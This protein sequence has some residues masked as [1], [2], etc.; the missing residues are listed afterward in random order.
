MHE[1][2]AS[3]VKKLSDIP[4]ILTTSRRRVL[5]VYLPA[6]YIALR[7]ILFLHSYEIFP[8]Q[9]KEKIPFPY[10]SKHSLYLVSQHG[11]FPVRADRNSRGTATRHRIRPVRVALPRRSPARRHVD[12]LILKC[13]PRR[14]RQSVR[15]QVVGARVLRGGERGSRR[16]VPVPERGDGPHHLDGLPRGRLDDLVEGDRDAVG[17]RAARA[18]RGR[19]GGGGAGARRGRGRAAAAPAVADRYV[20]AGQV[21]LAGLE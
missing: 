4:D 13:L 20:G 5:P 11:L 8:N 15:P 14:Q 7:N 18:G 6:I 21:D 10:D 2:V 19:R 17:G 12:K 9:Q 16:D 3:S 1:T